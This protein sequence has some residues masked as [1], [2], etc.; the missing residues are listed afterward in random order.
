[1]GTGT[2]RYSKHDIRQTTGAQRYMGIYLYLIPFDYAQMCRNFHYTPSIWRSRRRIDTARQIEQN[3]PTKYTFNK[4]EVVGI[5]NR[6]D[7]IK[8]RQL[9]DDGHLGRSY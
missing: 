9:H 2:E 8:R 7:R 3:L 1:M 6:Y 5:P 4:Q